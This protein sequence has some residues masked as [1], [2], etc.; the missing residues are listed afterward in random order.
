MGIPTGSLIEVSLVQ[1]YLA[2]QVLNVFQYAVDVPVGDADPVA[3]GN[4]W[5]NAVKA[6]YRALPQSSMGNV[7]DSVLVRQLNAPTGAYGQYAIPPA[8][9]AGTRTPTG[10]P[11]SLP[12]FVAAAVRLVVG[13]RVTRPGQKRFAFLNEADN[14]D[15]RLI[16]SYVVP[17]QALMTILVADMLLG[18]PS[19]LTDLHPIVVRKDAAGAVTAHQPVVG[20]IINPWISSQNTR[21][22]GRGA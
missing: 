17:L 2:Q 1:T 14:T 3:V 19:A 6:A 9:Q 11:E 5:W 8:E 12:P 4:A 16:S 21:K 7:F 15:G 10:A 13:S 20:Y 18:A 22:I